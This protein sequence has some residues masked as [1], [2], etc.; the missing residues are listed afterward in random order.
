MKFP[1]FIALRYLFARKSHNVINIV[2]AISAVGMAVGTAALIIILS[3]YNGFG[4]LVK[5]MLSSVEPDLVIVPSEGK[6]FVPEGPVYDWLYECP[7]VKNVSTVLQDN[8][9][10]EY[11]GSRGTAL[12]KGVDEIYSE[13][14]P[15]LD[16]VTGGE[17][18]LS[19]GEVRYAAVGEGFASAMGIYH[20]FVTELDMYYPDREARYSALNPL[21]SVNVARVWPSCEFAVNSEIDASLVIVAR[22]VMQGLL[23]VEDEVSAVEIRL[24]DG[25]R[26]G[27]VSAVQKKVASLAGPQFKVLDRTQQNPAL[28]RMLR[29]EKV[30]VYLIMVFIVLIL[31]FSIFGSLRML[32]IEK[33]D[34]IAT[35]RA[36]G[37]SGRDARRIF[38]LEGWFITL[39]GMIAG[40]AVGVAFCL[41]QQA[42]GLIRMPGT[43][44]VDAYPVVLEASDVLIS[45]I[46]IAV[47]GYFIALIP[48]RRINVDSTSSYRD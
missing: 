48:S 41:L 17:F 45:S 30:A 32:I 14:T 18:R 4:A 1:Y 42:T 21:G 9:F 36:M 16:Y 13:E 10:V 47:M 5:S 7:Q 2:S 31:G 25:S 43:F 11:D 34:D 20:G 6:F 44:V 29:Y 8:V 12:V 33:E 19:K 37:V 28:Y 3:V 35:L 39:S 27:D 26:A 15:I 38:T 46:S 23:G 22:D 24:V 40:L